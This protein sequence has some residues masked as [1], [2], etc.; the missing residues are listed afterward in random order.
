MSRGSLRQRVLLGMAWAMVPGTAAIAFT[1]PLP[2]LTALPVHRLLHLGG[3]ALFLGNVL[4]G[5]LWLALADASGSRATLRFA[6]RVINVADLAFTAPGAMLTVVNGAVLAGTWGGLF[7]VPWLTS[8][9]ALFGAITLLWAFVLVPLQ[10]RLEHALA[11]LP[12]GA[13]PLPGPLRRTLV[14]YFVVGGVTGAL[15]VTIGVI[16]VLK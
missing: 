10:V 13:G 1:G 12:E 14:V 5:A 6:T 8:S 2:A 15:A 4:V 16:M 3:A 9:V 11:A 7:A